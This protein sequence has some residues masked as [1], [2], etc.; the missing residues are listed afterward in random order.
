[1]YED[2][3]LLQT[4]AQPADDFVRRKD[5]VFRQQASATDAEFGIPRDRVSALNELDAGPDAA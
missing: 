3:A 4:I 5:G 1:M 2:K